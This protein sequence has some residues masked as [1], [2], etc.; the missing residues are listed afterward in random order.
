MT[1]LYICP[2]HKECNTKCPHRKPH[3]HIFNGC[4]NVCDSDDNFTEGCVPYIPECHI[5][6]IEVDEM[7]I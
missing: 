7:K 5:E 3:K 1:D 6:F 2:Y 4:D